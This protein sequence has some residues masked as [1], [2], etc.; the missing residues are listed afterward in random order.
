MCEGLVSQHPPRIVAPASLNFLAISWILIG[1]KSESTFLLV[2]AL[3]GVVMTAFYMTRMMAMTFFGDF[4]GGHDN[5]KYDDIHESP[6]L[7]TKI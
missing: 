3:I 5:I 1:V 2:I 7:M 6:N 4:K